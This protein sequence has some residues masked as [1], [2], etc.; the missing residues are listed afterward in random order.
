[1]KPLSAIVKSVMKKH[2]DIEEIKPIPA[3][4]IAA[5]DWVGIKCQYGCS[6]YGRS[7]SCPPATPTIGDARKVLDDY[8]TALFIRFKP[9]GLSSRKKH[10][11]A[12][13]DIE[14]SLLLS[15]YYKA[16]AFFPGPCSA[17]SKCAYPK[18]CVHPERKR[19]TAEAFGID[20]FL[21]ARNAGLPLSV[22]KEKKAFSDNSIVL[23]E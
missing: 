12:L 16:F 10:E 2:N 7:W 14:R 6:F 4:K 23:I 8:R 5:G 13:L 3:T 9:S 11:E 17:C 18:G 20:I 22:L 1:M 19:P 21:T 15:G